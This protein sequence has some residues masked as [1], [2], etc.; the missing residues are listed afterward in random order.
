MF[1]NVSLSTPKSR[2]NVCS[3]ASF[4]FFP[5]PIPYP[6]ILGVI[7][8]VYYFIQLAFMDSLIKILPK[9]RVEE[10]FKEIETKLN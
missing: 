3:L 4:F 7:E 2:L 10:I 9:D 6:G 5:H 8:Q 1:S